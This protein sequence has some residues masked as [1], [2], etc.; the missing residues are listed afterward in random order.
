MATDEHEARPASRWARFA[1]P[2]P[3]EE[4]PA[5]PVEPPRPLRAAPDA[6]VPGVGRPALVGAPPAPEVRDEQE[7]RND[8]AG[9]WSAASDGGHVVGPHVAPGPATASAG[10][11][12]DRW[13]DDDWPEPSRAADEASGRSLA[14]A[15]VV[16][17]V[18]AAPVGLV[19]GLVAAAR[20]RRAGASTRLAAIGIVLACVVIVVS[21]VWGVAWLDHVVRLAAA[22]RRVGPG[23]Y[24]TGD[25]STVTCS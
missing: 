16:F 5:A 9:T 10:S 15:S 3:G 19:L 23:D 14:I 22:C 21:V 1:R 7:A 12:F 4:R 18:F 13:G 2:A 24:L 17:A 11:P 6:G 8:R 20:A 25:G